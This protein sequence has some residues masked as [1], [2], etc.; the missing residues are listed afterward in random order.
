[1]A[2]A[3]NSRKPWRNF[4]MSLPYN[5][6]WEMAQKIITDYAKAAQ[7]F[8]DQSMST[9]YFFPTLSINKLMNMHFDAWGGGIE[10]IKNGNRVVKTISYYTRTKTKN[11]AMKYSLEDNCDVC[12]S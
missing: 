2:G 3:L 4:W 1:M 11:S 7:P 12:S 5:S 8:V 10:G 9:N 6:P